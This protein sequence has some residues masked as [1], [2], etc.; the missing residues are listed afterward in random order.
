MLPKNFSAEASNSSNLWSVFPLYDS[1]HL[2]PDGSKLN[3]SEASFQNPLMEGDKF[4]PQ[5]TSPPS[6]LDAL[7]SR[8]PSNCLLTS[9]KRQKVDCDLTLR[10]GSI[11][12]PRASVERSWSLQVENGDGSTLDPTRFKRRPE[13]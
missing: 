2:R 12:V 10:L 8:C 13:Q 4:V 9:G 11:V 3:P 6:K 5:L 7:D 1:D